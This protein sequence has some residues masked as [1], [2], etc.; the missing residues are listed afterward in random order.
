MEYDNATQK[1]LGCHFWLLNDTIDCMSYKLNSRTQ[2]PE[3]AIRRQTTE[4]WLHISKTSWGWFRRKGFDQR[5]TIKEVK[6]QALFAN[7]I[8]WRCPGDRYWWSSKV[9]ILK[10]VLRWWSLRAFSSLVLYHY[11]ASAHSNCFHSSIKQRHQFLLK[12]ATSASKRAT[13]MCHQKLE[14]SKSTHL[15][16]LQVTRHL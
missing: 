10:R 3:H 9:T 12:V 2:F 7:W 8:W 1:L 6:G 5:Q 4:D 14:F 15:L 11:F 16:L 13:F